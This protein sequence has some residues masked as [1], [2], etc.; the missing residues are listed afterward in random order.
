MRHIH[1][2]AAS[3]AALIGATAAQAAEIT[4]NSLAHNATT[5]PSLCTLEDAIQSA[6]DDDNRGLGGCNAGNGSDIITIT[7]SGVLDLTGGS[8]LPAITSDMTIRG[9]GADALA[10][11]G[12]GEHQVFVVEAG[13]TTI[14][15]VTIRNGSG[16]FGGGAVVRNGATLVLRDCRVTGNRAFNGGGVGNSGANLT[17][18]RCLIDANATTGN[19]GGAIV[20]VGGQTVVRSSTLSGNSATGSGSAVGGA[21]LTTDDEAAAFTLIV[22]S[23]ISDNDSPVGANLVNEMGNTTRLDHAVVANPQGGGA[24]C[25]GPITSLGYNLADDTSCALAMTGDQDDTAAGLEVLADNGGPTDTHLPGTGS[26]LIDRGDP[27]GC[28]FATDQRGEPRPTNGNLMGPAECDIGAVEVAPEPG[29]GLAAMGAS[30]LLAL[31]WRRR[32]VRSS[33]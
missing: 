12:Q 1:L 14:E 29:A 17:V 2:L 15:G 22:S 19:S 5:P 9:P 25:D 6:N 26:A 21:I 7:E 24:N 30:V 4:V 31:A 33:R 27:A 8:G 18:D 23:T 13:M 3:A 32:E 11:D 10:I 16:S 28:L 20:N